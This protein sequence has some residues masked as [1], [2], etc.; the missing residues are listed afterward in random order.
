MLDQMFRCMSWLSRA[1][2]RGQ[3]RLTKGGDGVEGEEGTAVRKG[4][5]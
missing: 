5:K 2:F 4:Q 3:G 1:R